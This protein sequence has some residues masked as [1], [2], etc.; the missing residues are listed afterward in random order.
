MGGN[1][2]QMHM[3]I[4]TVNPDRFCFKPSA[5]TGKYRLRS[6]RISLVKT[7]RRYFV[8]PDTASTRR[9]SPGIL[10]GQKGIKQ[11]H[12][13]SGLVR[14]S[15]ATLP[16]PDMAGGTVLLVPA[17]Y[18][19]RTCGNRGCADAAARTTTT[20]PRKLPSTRALPPTSGG[21]GCQRAVWD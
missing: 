18:T 6:S 19:S 1:S 4:F 10:S 20:P 7:P 21:G 17:K 14:V 12:S 16:Q 5:H 2:R 3:V 15:T 13:G 11:I 8:I 9:Q